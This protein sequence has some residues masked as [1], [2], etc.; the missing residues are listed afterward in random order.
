MFPAPDLSRLLSLLGFA[1][2]S[3]SFATHAAETLVSV[4]A[5]E[6]DRR[7]SI[8]SFPLP[9]G[10]TGPA[11]LVGR[12]GAAKGMTLAMQ[13]DD[14][15]RGWFVLP[16][17]NRGTTATFALEKLKPANLKAP[18]M[19]SRP[20]GTTVE[21][22][23][24][25]Q[26]VLRFQTETGELP[27]TNI[28]PIYRRGGYIQ[29]VF[30]PSGKLVTD[31]YPPNHI[32]HHGIWS[33][34]TKTE[35]EGRKPDFWNMGDGKGRVDFVALDQAWSGSVHAGFR[36]RQQFVDMLAQPEKVALHEAWE[37]RVFNVAGNGTKPLRLFDLVITQRCATTSPL[38][39][40]TYHYGGLG[41]R[42][43]RAWDGTNG[44]LFLTSEGITDRVAGNQTRGRWCWI[45]GEV[46]GTRT[47]I[48]ILGH[49]D[50][51]RAPQPMRLN[52]TEPFFCF[53][54]SQLGDWEIKPGE[55][56]VARYR[57]VVADGPPDATL[58]N[59]LWEDYAH[60]PQVAVMKR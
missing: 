36:S 48:A 53:A 49:P 19:Q 55:P 40:P 16:T 33:P 60:P 18:L 20:D 28:P 30:S 42:G 22:S 23:H 14:Q 41:F 12:E 43:H 37:L 34:W 7:E 47:G 25:G 26:P 51:F 15:R 59:R 24:S 4:S 13:S 58:L 9:N 2:L 29:S 45:G 35:F 11:Q 54:P 39:L 38:K 27:R 10:F 8:I 21:F 31:D 52:P 6:S 17:L 1:A 57:F 44:C 3:M 46:D 32:H 50:N 56:Y 5:G